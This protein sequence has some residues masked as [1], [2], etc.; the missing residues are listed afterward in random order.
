M[1]QNAVQKVAVGTA[2]FLNTDMDW[3]IVFKTVY[4]N[5]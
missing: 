5:N 1:E 3:K 4:R 2:H